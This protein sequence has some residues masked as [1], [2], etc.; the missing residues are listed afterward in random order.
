MNINCFISYFVVLDVD[1]C[2]GNNSC[3]ANAKC[4]NT[5]GSFYCYCK[6]GYKGDGLLCVKDETGLYVLADIFLN[7][8][9]CLLVLQEFTAT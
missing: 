6:S 8:W 2:V 4:V 9:D 3:S 1:E 5:D 7:F